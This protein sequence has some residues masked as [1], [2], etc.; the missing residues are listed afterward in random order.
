MSAKNWKIELKEFFNTHPDTPWSKN[1][2]CH[3]VC[4][5]SS[6]WLNILH[7]LLPV[8]ATLHLNEGVN[9]IEPGVYTLLY[10]TQ[11]LMFDVTK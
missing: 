11:V 8:V 9:H 7:N 5:F 6:L 10:M 1:H 4:S 2:Q 3:G